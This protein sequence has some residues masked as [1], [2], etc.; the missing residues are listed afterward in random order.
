MSFKPDAPVDSLPG[1]ISDLQ[2]D[3]ELLEARAKDFDNQCVWLTECSKKADN[4]DATEALKEFRNAIQD[5]VSDHLDPAIHVLKTK[6]AVLQAQLP[7]EFPDVV[8]GDP[9]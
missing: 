4:Y 8:H 1:N 2:D 5:A 6:L 9:E 7:A 3:I